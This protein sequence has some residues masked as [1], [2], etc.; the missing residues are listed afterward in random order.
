MAFGE[1]MVKPELGVVLMFV[2]VTEDENFLAVH[3]VCEVLDRVTDVATTET[4]I[5]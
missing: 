2:M 1:T 5:S 3:L 4:E